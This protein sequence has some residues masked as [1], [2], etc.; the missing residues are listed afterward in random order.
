MY[1][2]GPPHECTLLTQTKSYQQ[3][4]QLQARTTA[5]PHSFRQNASRTVFREFFGDAH[6]CTKPIGFNLD[7]WQEGAE[8]ERLIHHYHPG[9]AAQNEQR[10]PIGVMRINYATA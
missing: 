9:A 8:E 3:L 7:V 2:R 6:V 5:V 10:R 1:T 4:L